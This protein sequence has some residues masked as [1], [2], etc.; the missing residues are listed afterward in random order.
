MAFSVG[1]KIHF[2]LGYPNSLPPGW[3]LKE[4]SGDWAVGIDPN[5]REYYLGVDKA[6]PRMSNG[7]MNTKSGVIHLPGKKA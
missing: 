4:Q 6:Y 2:G 7:R 1:I 5:G 3:I